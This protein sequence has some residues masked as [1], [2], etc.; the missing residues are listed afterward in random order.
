MKKDLILYEDKS[1]IA[2][3]KPAG[4]PVQSD[5]TG[6]ISL[7]E[8]VRAYCNLDVKLLHRIDRPASGVVLF[9]KREKAAKSLYGQFERGTVRKTYWAVVGNK[10]EQEAAHLTHYIRKDGKKNRTAA[11]NKKLHHTKKAELKYQLKGSSEK[12][13]LLEI[14]LLTG[15]HH[16]IRAQLSA[17]GNAIRGDV[18]YGFKRGNKDRSIDLHARS[19]NF[20][21]PIKK[22]IM[23][24]V[25]SA[26]AMPIWKAFV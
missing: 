19:I 4:L 16:Q 1:I 21:H 17:T 3:N 20:M 2:I 23:T 26:P 15:R 8:Q 22:E 9:A 18:K 6:D 24:I 14:E 5:K 7:E 11:Y 12:Y 25:A 10:P 13:H